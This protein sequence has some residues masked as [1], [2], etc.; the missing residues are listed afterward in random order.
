[1][2]NNG[3]NGNGSGKCPF[4]GGAMRRSVSTHRSN[5]D[6]WPN[7]LDL[8]VLRQHSSLSDPMDEDFDYAAEFTSL[9]LEAVKKDIFDLMT[10]SQTWWPAE[11]PSR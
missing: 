2:E 10:D 4:T 1:M 7:M 3:Q 9:D 11:L 8:G 5:R 6:W